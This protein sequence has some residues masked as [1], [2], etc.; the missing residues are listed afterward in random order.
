[1]QVWWEDE[2][3]EAHAELLEWRQGHRAGS[4]QEA[5]PSQGVGEE[6]VVVIEDS[7]E[8]ADASDVESAPGL[9]SQAAAGL[10]L[11]PHNVSCA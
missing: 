10:V 2:T 7:E 8:A 9:H 4:S 5:G 3:R 6:D 1:M 11:T